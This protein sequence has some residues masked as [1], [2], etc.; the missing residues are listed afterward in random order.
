MTDPD[1]PLAG[2]A[3]LPTLL[4][5]LEQS[6]VGVLLLDAAGGVVFENACAREMAGASW[7]GAGAARLAPSLRAAVRALAGQGRPFRDVEAAIVRPDRARC[8]VVAS[9]APVRGADGDRALVVTFSDVTERREGEAARALAGR[10]EAAEAALRQAALGRPDA[11][12]LLE[13]AV[14]HLAHAFEA[15]AGVAFVG[16]DGGAGGALVRCAAVPPDAAPDLAELAPAAWPGLRSAAPSGVPDAVPAAV[17][18]AL[19]AP[20]AL[21]LAV[22]GAAPGVVLLARGAP[23]SEAER[24]A[25]TRVAALFSTLWAWT[26]AEARFQRTVADLDDALFTFGHDERG[27][28]V[29]AFVT[30]QAEAITGLD[31]AAVVAGD[32]DWA[33]L[34]HPD[35]RAA[36]DAHDARL[37]A[38][39]PSRVD[40]RLVPAQGVV[41]VSERAT[42]SLD[43]AG[44]PAAGG[45]LSDVTAQKEAEA[46]LDR[47]RRVAERASD[48]RM[49]FLRL[50]SHELRTP[51]G[52]I[53]GFADLLADEVAEMPGA[54]AVV[55]EFTATI[56]EAA[57]RALALVSDL[58]DLSRLETGTLGVARAPVD[59]A[60]IVR[61][62]AAR[63]A[64]DL[65]A[66]GVAFIVH[67]DGPATAL[68]DAG[69]LG[70]VV[71][72]LL[73]NAAAFTSHG[74][75]TVRA[76][77]TAAGV[78]V[79]VADTG[80]GIDEV[81]LESL[82]EPFAQEDTRVNRD[83][84]GTGLGLAIAR[85]LVAAMGGRLSVESVKGA[86]STF[87]VTLA[88]ASPASGQQPA[89]IG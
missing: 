77:A 31:P 56:G 24:A 47:A 87:T 86:G 38:G 74:S 1:P 73:A 33:A 4:A 61:A 15:T 67:A 85:R 26:D 63:V 51:L 54:P 12:A 75:V 52:A 41:W 71:R 22:R 42:P 17:L 43:A 16:A 9:G 27:R 88:A 70:Q 72:Q 68:A 2:D 10:V 28:R 36:F 3:A 55:A 14:A 83:R 59:V 13:T 45:L 5:V 89:A 81:F 32:A 46:T 69:R 11:L 20:H 80:A 25:G 82:F 34:V 7:V 23:F 18:A 40:V 65:A 60:L 21:A 8:V 49:A 79:S 58:L 35:D 53:R 44:R 48:A 66:R 30:P 50:V 84:E 64:P 57:T 39:H 62:E 6:P 76:A 37:R 78:A 19:S 29:Y